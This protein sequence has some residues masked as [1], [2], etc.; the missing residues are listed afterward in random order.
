MKRTIKRTVKTNLFELVTRFVTLTHI[1]NDLYEGFYY[2]DEQ[3][4]LI[5]LYKDTNTVLINGVKVDAEYLINFFNSNVDGY[6]IKETHMFSSNRRSINYSLVT[7][8]APV[9]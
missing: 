8:L 1:K 7:E 4:A 2:T 9:R 6:S 5:S 3:D